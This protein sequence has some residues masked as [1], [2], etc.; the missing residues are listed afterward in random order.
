MTMCEPRL[1]TKRVAALERGESRFRVRRP[2]ARR[3]DDP[4]GADLELRSRSRGRGRVAPISRSPSSSGRSRVDPRRRHG[5]AVERGPQHRERQS[6]VVLDPVVVDD[7]A[8]QALAPQVRRV[9]DRAR[10]PEVLREPA[11]PP[12]A[13]QVVQEDAAAVEALVEQ[14]DAVDREQERLEA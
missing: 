8:G 1:G 12:R 5:A 2:D 13:E 14:R 4:L 3:V 11:V 10:R 6:G 7:P 9:L